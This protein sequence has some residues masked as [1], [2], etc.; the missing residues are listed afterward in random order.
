MT[1]TN[2]PYGFSSKEELFPGVWVYRD[3]IKKELNVIDRLN[4]IGEASIRDNESRF[5]WT[6]GFVGYSEKRPSY[7]DCED[8][9]VGEINNPTNETQTL[10][11]DLWSDLKK[12][13]DVAVQDYCN[14]YNVKMNFWEVMNCIRYGKGQHFQEHADHGFSYSA[15]VS[16]VAYINDDYEGGNLFFP[17]IGL[18]IKPKAGD[19][20]IFPST[21][22]FSHRAMPV[23]EGQKFSIVTMLDYNDHAHKQEF[24]EARA[25]W[26]EEDAKTGKNSYA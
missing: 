13:Q 5:S 1:T 6:F 15:T 18:D 26:V 23:I 7:R 4:S 10:V 16:L 20:Y 24:F 21:Y 14:K 17:K 2:S 22:L 25:R 11:A 3:V 8:I 9:K 12:V 19:L